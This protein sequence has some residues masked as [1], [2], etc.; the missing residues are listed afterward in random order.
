MKKKLILQYNCW[1]RTSK[2]GVK[3]M[4]IFSL[5]PARKSRGWGTLKASFVIE[6]DPRAYVKYF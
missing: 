1:N 4:P 5:N 2:M 3:M 6:D